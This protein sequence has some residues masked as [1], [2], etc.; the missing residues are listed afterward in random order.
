MYC[1]RDMVITVL[2]GHFKC[3]SSPSQACS[4]N[5]RRIV[6]KISITQK[7]QESEDEKEEEKK[8]SIRKSSRRK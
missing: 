6:C 4:W 7:S 5:V 8:R 3:N 2:G 1:T